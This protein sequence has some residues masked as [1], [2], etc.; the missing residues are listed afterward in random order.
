[1]GIKT[2][3]RPDSG[4][5]FDPTARELVYQDTKDG[6]CT[7]HYYRDGDK[8]SEQQAHDR[9]INDVVEHRHGK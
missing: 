5:V 1:M 9:C 6:Y 7:S 2:Y 4:N 8:L 3:D